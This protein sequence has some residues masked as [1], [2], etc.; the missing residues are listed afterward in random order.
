MPKIGYPTRRISPEGYRAITKPLAQ[1][2]YDLDYPITLCGNNVNSY[3]V[4]QG[5]GLGHTIIKK[6]TNGAPCPFGYRVN[7]F[8][9]YMDRELGYYVVYYV[10]TEDLQA[11]NANQTKPR[12]NTP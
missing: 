11:Y 8:L 6:C 7:N 3:H 1:A 5:W 12:S 10:R 9:S 2:M 4:F